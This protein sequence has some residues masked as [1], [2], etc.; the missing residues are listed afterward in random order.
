[1]YARVFPLTSM[2]ARPLVSPA[3]LPQPALGAMGIVP[4]SMF[5]SVPAALPPV[6]P[7]R[8]AAPV[9]PAA[10]DVPPEPP[11]GM[12]PVPSDEVFD[13]QPQSANPANATNA[14][15]E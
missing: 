15:P 11:G 5:P 12:P 6:P 13:P 14:K 3:G 9:V 1:M 8:P 10:P 2:L 7:P 4:A